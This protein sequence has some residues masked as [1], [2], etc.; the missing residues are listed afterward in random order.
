MTKRHDFARH[1]ALCAVL[2]AGCP[3]DS[4]DG[5]T[6]GGSESSSSDDTSASATTATTS[7]PSTTTS[8]TTATTGDPATTSSDTDTTAAESSTTDAGE[9]DS[10][11]TEPAVCEPSGVPCDDCLIVDFCCSE[12]MACTADEGCAC[13]VEC[14][15]MG[16]MGE[17]CGG[18]CG[19][20]SPPPTLSALFACFDTAD[21]GHVCM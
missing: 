19:L 3:S 6:Q 11:T 1:R 21:C 2:L 8:A 5:T 14:M 4:D 12:F 17:E 15:M 16:G 9:S 13:V 20:A 10:S 7:D 18:Q